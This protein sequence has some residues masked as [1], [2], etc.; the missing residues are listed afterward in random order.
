MKNKIY[1]LIAAA[2]II[3]PSCPQPQPPVQNQQQDIR[4]TEKPAVSCGRNNTPLEPACIG[5][6]PGMPFAIGA[7]ADDI[8]MKLGR[9]D[10]EG[11][12]TGWRY[13][14][15]G[16]TTYFADT[17]PGSPGIVGMIG[18]GRGTKLFG[19]T[20]GMSHHEIA[21]VLGPPDRMRWVDDI[22]ELISGDCAEYDTGE[23]VLMFT[24]RTKGGSTGAAY[25]CKK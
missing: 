12:I 13:L 18:V 14:S 21:K 4:Q 24:S 5:R 25:L 7:K 3:L 8:L 19:I 6:L 22:G 23:Y 9:P 1:F 20:V 16:V 17:V 15:Y 11:F 2:I 10:S